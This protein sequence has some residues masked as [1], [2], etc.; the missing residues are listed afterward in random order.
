MKI[1]IQCDASSWRSYFV[2]LFLVYKCLAHQVREVFSCLELKWVSDQNMLPLS[3]IQHFT[4]G[5]L[6]GPHN[7]AKQAGKSF[8][9]RDERAEAH[10][11][12][13]TM[14]LLGSQL[15][16]FSPCSA[17]VVRITQGRVMSGLWH[18]EDLE[19]VSFFPRL[20]STHRETDRDTEKLA[21][22]VLALGNSF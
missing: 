22:F 4:V 11:W 14:T 18:R 16:S 21:D 17:A 6:T 15:L 5:F 1:L 10:S 20:V 7:P 8:H 13:I 9:F 19:E 3:P 12:D 2:G